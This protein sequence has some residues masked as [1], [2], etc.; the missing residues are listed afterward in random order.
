MTEP[1]LD[2]F[3][4]V[5]VGTKY[6]PE[7]PARLRRMILDHCVWGQHHYQFICVTDRGSVPGWTAVHVPEPGP[8]FQGWWAKMLLFD[9]SVR[10]GAPDALYF[11]LDTV[12]CGPLP[13]VTASDKFG[14]LRNLTVLAGHK[15]WPCKFGSAV[16]HFPSGWGGYILDAYENAWESIQA[17]C[18]KGDQQAIE[19]LI[20]PA[21][22]F[23][24]QDRLPP[25][26]IISYRDINP[27]GPRAGPDWASVVCF[28]GSHRPD[29]S[30]IHWIRE[31]WREKE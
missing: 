12:I 3:L 20:N 9:P 24:L 19:R 31:V 17:S 10:G 11:D 5:W 22:W 8:K 21:D 15:S 29:N 26:Q 18:P 2:T 7:Y 14:I 4:C 28:G 1:W 6:G 23:Y 27:A 25:G 16:M 13:S 30:S